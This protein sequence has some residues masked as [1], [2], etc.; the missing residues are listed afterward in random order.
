MYKYVHSSFT[1]ITYWNYWLVWEKLRMSK[2]CNWCEFDDQDEHGSL[3]HIYTE[4]QPEVHD[5]LGSWRDF[6]ETYSLQSG[7][8][9][10]SFMPLVLYA[11]HMLLDLFVCLVLNCL[12]KFL[13]LY[14]LLFWLYR[15]HVSHSIRNNNNHFGAIVRDNLGKLVPE[16]MRH[17][18]PHY[19]QCPF[20]RTSK[21][22]RNI[23]DTVFSPWVFICAVLLLWVLKGI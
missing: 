20:P 21:M 17:H 13:F 3:R 18:N 6:I 14:L 16:M 15:N 12:L 5:F 9:M 10:W 11:S 1:L 19:Q 7:R 23:M 4:W 2:C 8:R 22:G